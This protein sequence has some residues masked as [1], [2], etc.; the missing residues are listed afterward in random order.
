MKRTIPQLYEKHIVLICGA[1][2]CL[3]LAAVG[4]WY[5]WKLIFR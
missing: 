3:I 2:C 4:A 5:Y 1:I